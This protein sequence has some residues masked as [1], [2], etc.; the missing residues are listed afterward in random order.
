[1]NERVLLYKYISHKTPMLV[2]ASNI[3]LLLALK[4]KLF[5]YKYIIHTYIS[6]HIHKYI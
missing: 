6:I 2:L 5:S 3:A 1:M 4:R